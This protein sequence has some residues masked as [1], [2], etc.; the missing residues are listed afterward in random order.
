MVITGPQSCP[1]I[2]VVIWLW[3]GHLVSGSNWQLVAEP[4]N[5]MIAM[6]NFPWLPQKVNGKLA[7]KV[8]SS[9]GKIFH[10]CAHS[11]TLIT[12]LLHPCTL[13]PTCADLHMC[14]TFPYTLSTIPYTFTLPKTPLHPATSFLFLSSSSHFPAYRPGICS[15]LLASPLTLTVVSQWEV[16]SPKH[17]GI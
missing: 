6:W 16:A 13:S 9:W 2:P 4:C 15:I 11:P 10:I 17:Y 3:P 8:A 7:G 5:H 1:S 14:C 12:P